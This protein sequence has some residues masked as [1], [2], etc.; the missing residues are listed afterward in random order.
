MHL[1]PTSKLG[2]LSFNRNYKNIYEI[3]LTNYI[4]EHINHIQTQAYFRYL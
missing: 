3:Q 2:Y 1:S 4:Y